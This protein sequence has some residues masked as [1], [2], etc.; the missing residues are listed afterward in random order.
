MAAQT[1]SAVIALELERVRTKVPVM[2]DREGKFYS[3]IDKKQVEVISNRQM[4]IPLNLRPGGKSGFF[5][6]GG[7]DLGRG[8]GPVYDK[9]VLSPLSLKHA[10]EYQTLVEWVTDD[11][12][13]AVLNSVQKMLADGMKELRR[14]CDA[15]AVGGGDGVIGTIGTVTSQTDFT[16][17]DSFGAKL[18]R[19]N[20][21]INI[22][23]SDLLTRRTTG[24][25]KEITTHDLA[26]KRIV[27]DSAPVGTVVAG[28]KIVASGL[29]AT[30][31]VGIKGVLYHHD[32]ASTGTWLGFD[33][34]TT[35]EI[36]AN[37]VN[38]NGSPFSLPLARLAVNK[39]ADR[40]GED[41]VGKCTAWMHPNQADAYEQLGQLVQQIQSS[42]AQKGTLDR[43][44]GSAMVMAGC[45]VKTSFN[46]HRKR[47]DFI[48][49]NYWGR[50][51]LKAL[52]YHEVGGRRLFEVR[53][54]SGGVAASTLVYLVGSFDL[55]VDNPAGCSY[56]DNLALVSGY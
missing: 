30:P 24:G 52:G 15:M 35:P 56:I 20:Q 47:I 37:R 17:D 12:R 39:A 6:P 41:Q 19:F 21:D 27:I 7:G 34:S 40:V 43:Y 55:F 25:E 38:A 9:A 50:G 36:R 3:S 54:A 10:M 5:N 42:G 32:S 44:F 22:Y 33:R 49:A 13:K 4:R 18:V 28:D 2:F 8:S 11:K 14:Y 51:E 23:S 45:P 53:G 26:L 29:S 46:W 16:L 48:D 31:P 1:E